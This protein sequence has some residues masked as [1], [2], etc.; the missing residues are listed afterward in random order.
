M[1]YIMNVY[2][3]PKNHDTS[4][5]LHQSHNS[6]LSRGGNGGHSKPALQP[7]RQGPFLKKGNK[8]GADRPQRETAGT[9]NV[10]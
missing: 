4:F 10:G 5:F 3:T 9:L 1:L 2:L 6:H 8:R 7:V